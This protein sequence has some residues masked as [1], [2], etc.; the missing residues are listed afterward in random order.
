MAQWLDDLKTPQTLRDYASEED[1]AQR[2]LANDPLLSADRA[3]WLAPHWSRRGEDGRWHILGDPA[4]KRTNP[5]LYR[6][7]ET[8]ETWR[9]ITAPLLWVEGDLTDIAKWWGQRYS[10]AEFH[11]RLGVVRQVRRETIASAGHMLHH[12][13]PA[14]L[15]RLLRD[16]LA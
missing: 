13:Q 5:V 7:D 11:E 16:F 3:A 8:L 10:K 14:A 1:V 15:A 12:D 4:H 9:Q 6:V 2:L